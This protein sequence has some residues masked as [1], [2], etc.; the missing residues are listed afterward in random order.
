MEE[1][2]ETLGCKKERELCLAQD[3]HGDCGCEEDVK[4]DVEV[5]RGGATGEGTVVEGLV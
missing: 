5:F 3:G 2:D 4:A 1:L